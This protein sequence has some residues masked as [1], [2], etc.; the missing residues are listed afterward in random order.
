[1]KVFKG[2]IPGQGYP[3][4]PKLEETMKIDPADTTREARPDDGICRDERA[5]VPYL[6]PDATPWNGELPSSP[7]QPRIDDI[8]AKIDR[9]KR[10][11]RLMGVLEGLNS[12]KSLIETMISA[13]QAD[14][15]AH[16]NRHAS[17][18]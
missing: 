17:Q 11:A 5:R 7:L 15:Q 6:G 18:D 12:C 2:S 14:M 13:A 10:S 4:D 3:V 1:M 8:V 9:E 16:R